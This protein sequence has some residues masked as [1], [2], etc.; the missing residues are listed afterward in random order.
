MRWASRPYDDSAWEGKP[1]ALMGASPGM[2]GTA[3]AQYH[4]RQVFVTLNMYPLNDPEVMIANASK[5][6][7]EQGNL[8]DEGTREHIRKLVESLVAWTRQ[9]QKART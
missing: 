6:F 8:T 2:L 7:D 5:R 9:L 4:L 3:R 1:V